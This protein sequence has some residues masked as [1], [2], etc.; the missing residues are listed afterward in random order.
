[1]SRSFR[2][3]LAIRA[4]LFTTVAMGLG[5][6]GMFL[7]LRGSLDRELNANILNVAT[8]Q[9]AALT[10][11]ETGEM[12][13]H[14]WDLTP[15]EAA[16]IQELVRYAQ[17]WDAS[18][19]S[20]LRSQYMTGD[21]PLGGESR[22]RA[23]RGELLWEEGTFGGAPIRSLL[24]PLVR[25]GEVHAGHVLQVAAP[26]EARNGMLLRAGAFGVALVLLAGMGSFLGGRWLAV[27][28]V[29]P[30]SDIIDEA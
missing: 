16:S 7:V 15:A 24:Y 26:L 13:F 8:I 29:L 17:V 4:A 28:M 25:M 23:S 1:M 18:G 11:A 14:E 2:D 21:L 19:E 3:L 5:A 20:L 10:D 9:A 22:M 30:V 27:R 12:H 6:G